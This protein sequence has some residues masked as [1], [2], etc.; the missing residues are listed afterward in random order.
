M[1]GVRGSAGRGEDGSHRRKPAAVTGSGGAEVSSAA[2][3][4]PW[5]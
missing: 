2:A 4:V 5:L 3:S 1:A